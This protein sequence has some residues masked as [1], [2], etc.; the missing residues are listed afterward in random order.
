MGLDD[1][2]FYTFK[3]ISKFVWGLLDVTS[4]CSYV[5]MHQ[6]TWVLISQ[7][8][9]TGGCSQK[10]SCSMLLS[11]SLW[12]HLWHDL[13]SLDFRG[14]ATLHFQLSVLP[15][16][17]FPSNCFVILFLQILQVFLLPHKKWRIAHCK[18][19]AGAW[20]PSCRIQNLIAGYRYYCNFILWKKILKNFCVDFLL[21]KKACLNV[22]CFVSVCLCVPKDLGNR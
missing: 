4:L 8:L 11:S 3:N 6:F 16:V 7:S 2:I 17:C 9:P 22:N 15:F 14:K 19:E 21:I 20:R 1:K 13:C 18:L 5:Y 12:Q 10:S